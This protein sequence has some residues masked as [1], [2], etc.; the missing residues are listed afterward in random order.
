MEVNRYR[1][2]AAGRILS[3]LRMGSLLTCPVRGMIYYLCK[4]FKFPPCLAGIS[5]SVIEYREEKTGE[6]PSV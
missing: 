2:M 5:K 3:V 1:M 6:L 4:N